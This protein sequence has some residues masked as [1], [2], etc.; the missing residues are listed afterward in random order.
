[1]YNDFV[2][3]NENVVLLTPP[4]TA[5]TNVENH[6]SGGN[7]LGRWTHQLSSVSSLS[8]QAYYDHFQQQQVGSTETQ[9]AFDLDAQHRFPIGERN[10]II[11]GLGYRY[12]TA[13]SPPNFYLTW[14]PPEQSTQ[15]YSAFVQDE[16]TLIP[17]LF[18]VTIGSKFEHNDVTGLEIQ[19]SVRVL[20]TPTDKQT[21]WAAVSRAVRTPSRYETGA[22]VNYSVSSIPSPPNATPLGLVSLF[23]NPNAESENLIAYEL[24]YR[25]EATKQLSF[26]VATFYNQY[27]KLLRFVTNSSYVQG[28]VV[29]FPQ[30]IE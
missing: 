19:P 11:W 15:L 7:I 5:T 13:N 26:D 3:E 6:D 21:V 27:D 9:D 10:D 22:R 8:I 28:P 16:I 4:F 23:G 25:I 29:V 1:M 17:S 2:H 30:T 18:S 14:T 12:T 20:W 24:G